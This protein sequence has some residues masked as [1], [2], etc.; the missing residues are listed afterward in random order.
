MET[1]EY[2]V[3]LHCLP[4]I[5]DL[6][7]GNKRNRM[8]LKLAFRVETAIGKYSALI[9][10]VPNITDDALAD[11][12]VWEKTFDTMEEARKTGTEEMVRMRVPSQ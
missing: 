11:L 3:S 9:S 4:H 6:G 7:P 5:F 12:L 8:V 2:L 10:E 1:K